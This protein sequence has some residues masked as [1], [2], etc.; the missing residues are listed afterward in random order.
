MF[1]INAQYLKR[2]IVVKYCF[3]FQYVRFFSR[4]F[5]L[6][7]FHHAFKTLINNSVKIQD[8]LEISKSAYFAHGFQPK[9]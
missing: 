5:G 3:Y 9:K 8:E 6:Y 4:F 7:I 1:V 2:Y